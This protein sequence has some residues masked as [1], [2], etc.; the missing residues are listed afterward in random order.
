[1]PPP[2][3]TPDPSHR[4]SEA[5]GHPLSPYRQPPMSNTMPLEP[6]PA[7]PGGQQPP[8]VASS[9]PSSALLIPRPG[10]AYL[11][12]AA[13]AVAA[14]Y[15]PPPGPGSDPAAVPLG[16]GS[17]DH[18]PVVGVLLDTFGTGQRRGSSSSLAAKPAAAP[19]P[20]SFVGRSRGCSPN[21]SQVDLVGA[22]GLGSELE[23]R[24]K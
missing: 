7:A 1:M 6:A 5:G 24:A 11:A 20:G 19:V 8:P 16:G 17:K 2:P 22:A 14:D 10:S 12:A 4:Q 23:A 9:P 21:G 18:L 13:A 15:A 3:P